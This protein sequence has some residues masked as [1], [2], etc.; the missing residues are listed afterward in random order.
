MVQLITDIASQTNLLAL[1]ATIEA[2][3]GTQQVSG[4]IAGVSEAAA[5]TGGASREVLTA[6]DGLNHEATDLRGFVSRFLTDMRAA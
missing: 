3:R 1:N 5:S 4:N 2:A 6:A